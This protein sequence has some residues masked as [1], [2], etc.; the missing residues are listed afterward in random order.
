M[1]RSS[2]ATN[3]L[4]GK[5]STSVDVNV[6]RV[7]ETVS[8][9]VTGGNFKQSLIL[10]EITAQD[11]QNRIVGIKSQRFG[12]FISRLN[13]LN[14]LRYPVY[15][16]SRKLFDLTEQC[17]AAIR[18]ARRCIRKVWVNPRVSEGNG[19]MLTIG[20]ASP[21]K[22]E[23]FT[24]WTH[25]RLFGNVGVNFLRPQLL[26]RNGGVFCILKNFANVRQWLVQRTSAGRSRLNLGTGPAPTLDESFLRQRSKRLTYRKTTDPII[27]AE[28][29]FSRKRLGTVKVTAQN[30]CTQFIRKF[31]VT[32]SF[33]FNRG[34]LREFHEDVLRS[35]T[36]SRHIGAC[37]GTYVVM[38]RFA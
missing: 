20:T 24:R 6:H 27:F 3:S 9:V 31:K 26:E 34:L 33:V 28:R 29:R 21:A 2:S 14:V 5:C 7:S 32:C 25:T 18:E 22:D 38:W 23:P 30:C 11:Q 37:K 36:G 4:P 12:N 16:T 35:Q 13:S 8:G 10:I 1:K 15:S 17:R 19:A